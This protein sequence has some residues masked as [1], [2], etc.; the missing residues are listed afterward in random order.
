MLKKRLPH[1]IDLIERQDRL[2]NPQDA[3]SGSNSLVKC[4]GQD[5]NKREVHDRSRPWPLA[6]NEGEN[7]AGSCLHCNCTSGCGHTVHEPQIWRSQ[8][9]TCLKLIWRPNTVHG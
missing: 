6:K 4:G 5:R 2:L 1:L 3:L 7:E 9:I 8:S